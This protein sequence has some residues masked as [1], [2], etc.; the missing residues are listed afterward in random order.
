MKRDMKIMRKREDELEVYANGNENAIFILLKDDNQG[1]IALAYNLVFH[2]KT[3]HM[4]I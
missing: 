1:S 3:K 4:N 2:F